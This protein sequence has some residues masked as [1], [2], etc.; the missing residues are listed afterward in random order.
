LVS[1]DKYDGP[2]LTNIE[3]ILV[4]SI[5]LIQRM[6]EAKSRICFRLQIPLSL[7]W[8][9]TVHKLQSLTLTNKAVIDLGR[10]EFAAGL[11]FV[12]ISHVRS[13][14]DILF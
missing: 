6:W 4:V 11:S 10:K 8:T 3:G 5:V 1:F 12:M 9:I 2:T 7:A 14:N 13:L